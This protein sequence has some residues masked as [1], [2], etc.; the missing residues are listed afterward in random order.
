MFDR[1][2]K[3]LSEL[4]NDFEVINDIDRCVKLTKVLIL[5]KKL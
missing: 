2:H 1:Y 4:G 5:H 3:L